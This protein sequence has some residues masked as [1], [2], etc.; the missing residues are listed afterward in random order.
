MAG[1]W[2]NPVGFLD[3]GTVAADGFKER[4]RRSRPGDDRKAW[5]S[6]TVRTLQSHAYIEIKVDF[7]GFDEVLL[8]ALWGDPLAYLAWQ[9]RAINPHW[10]L[11]GADDD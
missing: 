2:P 6:Q 7:S 5:D 1:D 8:R 3:I 10:Y 4:S 11:N 9:F